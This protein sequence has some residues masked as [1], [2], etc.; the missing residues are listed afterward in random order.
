MFLLDCIE[1]N[2]ISKVSV[3]V[4]HYFVWFEACLF[5]Y[6]CNNS[7]STC[8]KNIHAREIKETRI[9]ILFK[10]I[11]VWTNT[12][13][14]GWRL[15][16][17]DKNRQ[18]TYKVNEQQVRNKRQGTL[19]RC[20]FKKYFSFSWNTC[21]V[22]YKITFWRRRKKKFFIQWTHLLPR[23]ILVQNDDQ[24]VLNEARE[25]FVVSLVCSISLIVW[26]LASWKKSSY[27]A[28]SGITY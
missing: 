7:K 9:R 27:S 5:G 1:K 20:V 25:T 21:R 3:H 17:E 10:K 16:M 24:R 19:T 13:I 28:N 11:I 15:D 2:N 26:S 6:Y 14:Q 22:A 23:R 12:V 18:R 4:H 8:P